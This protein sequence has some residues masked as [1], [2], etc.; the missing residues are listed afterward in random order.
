MPTHVAQALLDVLIFWMLTTPHEFAHAWVATMLGD[1][2]PRRDGRVTLNPAAHVD[3]MG[4]VIV[5]L[6]TSL[7]GAG[8]LGWGRPVSTDPRKLRGGRVGLAVVALAGPASNVV[9]AAIIALAANFAPAHS[10]LLFRAAY[11]SIYLAL[12]NLIPLPPLDG[13]KV[14]LAA[15]FPVRWYAELGRYGFLLL[16]MLFY[17]TGAGRLLQTATLETIYALFRV[18]VLRT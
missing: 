1:D 15:G 8:F 12:F 6:A 11:M 18:L 5:P 3:W 16:L 9:F 2:T 13:S 4:T 10:E 17:S 7:M 14:L